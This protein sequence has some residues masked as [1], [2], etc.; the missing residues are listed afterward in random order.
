MLQL[1]QTD[2]DISESNTE[3]L[4]V[5]E[6]IQAVINYFEL[7]KYRGRIIFEKDNNAYNIEAN[8]HLFFIALQNIIDNACKYSEKQVVVKLFQTK[9]GFQISVIDEGI[10]IPSSEKDKIFDTFYR[11]GNTSGYKGSGI[12]LSLTSK[13]LKLS[14]ADI[15]IESSENKGTAV[16]ITWN[17]TF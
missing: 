3:R 16:L 10:G 9:L 4:V 2:L 13:I 1:A 5:E 12:G 15:K 7:S 17:H 11:A 8:K 6:E 14:R